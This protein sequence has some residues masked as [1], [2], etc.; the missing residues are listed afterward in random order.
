MHYWGVWW[1]EEPFEIYEEKVG[2]FMS[3]YGFQGF[4]PLSTLDSVL[5]EKQKVLD[6]PALLNHQKHPRGM[7]LIQTYMERDF[8]VPE[9]V[10]QYSYIS[11]LVQGY[12]MRQA[13]EAHRRA[14]PRCMGT[15]YWQLNDCW[16]VISWSGLD[17]YGR[18]KALHYFVKKAYEEVHV[19]FG[20]EGENLHVHVLSDVP[21]SI[22]GTLVVRRM[23]FDGTVLQADSIELS[24]HAGENR[25]AFSGT[26]AESDSSQQFVHAVFRQQ[27]RVLSENLHFFASPKS[28]NL[29]TP[30]IEWHVKQENASLII[31]IQSP[32]LV[33]NLYLYTDQ[34]GYFSDN[35]FDLLPG[36]PVEVRYY[37]LTEAFEPDIPIRFM[38]LQQ[39]LKDIY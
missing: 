9:D 11:Q 8:P 37:P 30:Q 24:L 29:G 21:D 14:K 38:H 18:W 7:E 16:P 22:R 36:D 34:D 33:K 27:D 32:Q 28:L 5:D 35:F 17:Y 12:G 39:L 13:I 15:L 31:R 23:N 2:R 26:T 10:H 20:S 6:S 3:E 19:S 25:R 1:G 4:P